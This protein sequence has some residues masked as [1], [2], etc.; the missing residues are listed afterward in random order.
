MVTIQLENPIAF[1]KILDDSR[2]NA[3]DSSKK[4]DDFKNN[5]TESMMQD[6]EHQK[7]C[8][9]RTCNTIKT[10]CGNLKKLHDKAS[11]EHS[12]GIAKL[13]VEIA[14]KILSQK[15]QDKDY[16]IEAIIKKALSNA[17]VQ[18]DIV[19]HL[20]PE[21]LTEYQKIQRDNNAEI[22]TDIKFVSDANIGQAEC[23]IETPK[24]IIESLIDSH[25]E[26]VSKALQSSG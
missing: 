17:T 14:R 11:A 9:S 4:N 20:N 12:E 18:N 25:L 7:D 16:E 24:G 8:F 15:V 22:S 26:Q 13:A 3:V 1:V 5:G 10:V 2:N 6:I 19:V 23:L 21:D